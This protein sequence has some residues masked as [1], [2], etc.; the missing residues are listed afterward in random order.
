MK[1]NRKVSLKK[2]IGIA[3]GIIGLVCAIVLVVGVLAM[4]I[5]VL[6]ASYY[7]I[8]LDAPKDIYMPW[9][10]KAA[11]SFIVVLCSLSLLF[12]FGRAAEELT[13]E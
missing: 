5:C 11:F 10:D 13:D 12:V 1:K 7:G 9:A 4:C 2:G 6:V 3:M 8:I